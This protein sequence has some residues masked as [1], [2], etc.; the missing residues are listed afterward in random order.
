MREMISNLS[1]E[2]ITYVQK[3]KQ[4]LKNV[5]GAFLEFCRRCEFNRKS[6]RHAFFSF[7]ALFS[8]WTFSFEKVDCHV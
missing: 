6:S 8:E 4:F 5:F 2:R 3:G 7:V 1:L